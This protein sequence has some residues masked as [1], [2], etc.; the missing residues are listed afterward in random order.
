MISCHISFCIPSCKFENRIA[1]QTSFPLEPQTSHAT[2]KRGHVTRIFPLLYGG[3][4]MKI[5]SSEIF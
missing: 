4:K 1:S 2:L 3:L 5:R